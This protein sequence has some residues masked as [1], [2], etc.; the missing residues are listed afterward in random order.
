M[1]RTKTAL[2]VVVSALGMVAMH[3]VKT[4]PGDLFGALYKHVISQLWDVPIALALLGLLSW[5]PPPAVIARAL[6]LCGRWS[7][8]LYLGHICVY[9]ISLLPGY[10]YAGGPLSERL[11]FYVAMLTLGAGLAVAGHELRK[12]LAL[13][14]SQRSKPAAAA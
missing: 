3:A 12:R 5:F 14:R 1:T 7:W 6:A 4:G 10:G 2:A 11:L 9:E 8:G 13:L